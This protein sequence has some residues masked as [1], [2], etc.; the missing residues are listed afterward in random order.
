M[1]KSYRTKIDIIT[2]IL[3]ALSI[4]NLSKTGIMYKAY[5]SYT[6]TTKYIN[7]ILE[8]NLG[9]YDKTV[10]MYSITSKGKKYLVASKD[11]EVITKPKGN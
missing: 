1:V 5:L 4:E 11:L 7:Y 9:E 3:L 8:N 2:K 6:Q 10:M